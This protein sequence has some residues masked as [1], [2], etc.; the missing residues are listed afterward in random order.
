MLEVQTP[1]G[2]GLYVRERGK[3]LPLLLVHGF[4][5]SSEAWGE[6]LLNELASEF[7]LLAVDL[8]GHGCSNRP[9]EPKRYGLASQVRDLCAVL[10]SRNV[11]RAV[12]LGYSMG[13]R[14]ALG[15]A[16]LCPQRIRGLVLES[17]SPGL[18]SG[19]E[20][21]AR[22]EQD[23]K[24]ARRLE[25]DG[26]EAFVAHWMGLPLFATQAK[27]GPAAHERE[28]ERRLRNDPAA[29]AA[30]LRGM[31]TGVQPSFWTRL[32]EVRVPTLV[33]AGSED[34]KFCALARRMA[35]RLP[36]AQLELIRGAGHTPHLEQPETYLCHVRDFCRRLAAEAPR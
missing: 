6:K 12:C 26:L 24:L 23:E 4:T 8:I 32:H 28:R 19:D 34:E 5:G 7:R 36:Q 2:G 27:L 13:G 18:D 14:I 29:L 35:A 10:D 11:K 30:S 16:L 3:G 9:H 21:R 22:I 31:G 33:L 1:D 17:A 20:R 25:D 15:A